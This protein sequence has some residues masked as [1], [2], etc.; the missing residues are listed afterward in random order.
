[1]MFLPSLKHSLRSGLGTATPQPE[2][3]WTD[4][5]D[6]KSMA[7]FPFYRTFRVTELDRMFV[8]DLFQIQVTS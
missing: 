1:M 5:P 8:G 6:R 2:S 7:T 3:R 4:V